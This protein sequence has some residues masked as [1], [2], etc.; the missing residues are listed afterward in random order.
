MYSERARFLH[1]EGCYDGFTD[2]ED[3]PDLIFGTADYI[4][5]AERLASS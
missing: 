2:N 5:Q 1:Q 3:I 4:R